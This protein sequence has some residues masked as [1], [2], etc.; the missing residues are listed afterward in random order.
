MDEEGFKNNYEFRKSMRSHYGLNVF[1]MRF[2]PW[3]F[4]KLRRLTVI[5]RD[6]LGI[7]RKEY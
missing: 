7:K 3:W 6:R 5:C 1:E 2:S 4:R